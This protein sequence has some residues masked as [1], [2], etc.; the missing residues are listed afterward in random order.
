MA[1][2]GSGKGIQIIVG[3][4]YNDKDLKRAQRD[5]DKLKGEAAKS[6]G[7][8]QKLGTTLKNNLGPA[9]A[10]AGIAAGALAIKLG[11][12]GV[13]AAI[14]DQKTVEVLAQT[15]KNLGEAHRQTGVE[16]FIAS[17]ESA[18]GVADERLRPALGKLL[19]ATGDVDEAQRRLEQAMDISVG[20]GQE[21][22]GVVKALGRAAATGT[23][24]PLSRFGLILNDNTIKTK[25]FNVALDEAAAKFKG[26]AQREAKTLEGQLR[27]V[28]IEFDNLKEA[29]GYGFLRGIGDAEEGISNFTDTLRDLKP[30]LDESGEAVGS[31]MRRLADIIGV[32]M[33]AKS[34]FDEF[35]SSNELLSSALDTVARALP[36]VGAFFNLSD[37]AKTLTASNEDLAYT[38]GTVA[39]AIA[40]GGRATRLAIPPTEE[41]AEA[42]EA[43]AEAAEKAAKEFDKL[44]AAI[45]KTSAITSYQS[46]VDKLTKAL[47]DAKGETSVFTEEGRKTVDAYVDLAKNAG[48]YIES[49]DSTAQKAATARGLLATLKQ[50][51]GNTKMDPQTQAALLAPFQG[52]IDDLRESGIDVD[53]LQAK[54]DRIKS[55]TITVTV[56]TSTVGGRP[57]GVSDREWYGAKGG[58]V[59]KFYAGGGMTR[60][61]D[62]VPAMLAP[63]EFIIRR[64]S[65]KQFGTDLFS[66]LNRGINPLAG[67]TPTRGQGQSG[68]HIENINV[69]TVAGERA[70]ESI[71]RALRRMAFLAGAG[72][73]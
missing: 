49:L 62:T 70:E 34:S 42:L 15:L 11:V 57:P 56:K 65:V 73:G 28:G 17:M 9:L 12:D 7:P 4:D 58:I 45:K 35:I 48:E 50:Q 41:M 55:K 23:A 18:Y 51:L 60:G 24:G 22:E 6:A 63:G 10:A 67:M 20:T 72:N 54:L 19:V 37:A 3:T 27:I 69:T 16:Q 47:K 32:V 46:A 53:R 25:G 1:I 71:P 38:S 30:A 26:M 21:L 29:F 44:A 59:P 2:G 39:A 52:L 40:E 36:I 13:K 43:E 31:T 68:M 5:L 8:F 66:Q 33:D 64:Q 14:A 61:S